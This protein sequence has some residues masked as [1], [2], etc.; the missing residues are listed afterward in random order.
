MLVKGE[1]IMRIKNPSLWRVAILAAVVALALA[2]PRVRPLRIIFNQGAIGANANYSE[3]EYSDLFGGVLQ[4]ADDFELT[5]DNHIVT[6]VR[7]W[8]V[9]RNNVPADDE[10]T[11]FAYEIYDP[12]P[13]SHPWYEYT[14][15]EA[16]RTATASTITW[17]M[18]T[19]TVYEYNLDIPDGEFVP[20]TPYALS[21]V[22]NTGR[23]AWVVNGSTTQGNDVGW[24]RTE[25][26]GDWVTNGIDYAFVLWSD[27]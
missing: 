11:I 26:Y 9:Y 2:C 18:D 19:L 14:S 6:Q 17:G 24:A 20:D 15:T 16:A 3:L 7:W 22:N 1:S 10:F 8:G 23:W 25:E 13:Q 21:I 27:R 5:D 12:E 4:M